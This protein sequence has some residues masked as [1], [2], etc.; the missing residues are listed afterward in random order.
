MSCIFK[1]YCR[2]QVKK[3]KKFKTLRQN[4]AFVHRAALSAPKPANPDRAR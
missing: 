1:F 2:Y 4:T 3:G